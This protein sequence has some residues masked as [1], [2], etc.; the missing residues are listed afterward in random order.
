M[1]LN[2]AWPI[3][4]GKQFSFVR[5]P[6]GRS[7]IKNRNLPPNSSQHTSDRFHL[8]FSNLFIH[9]RTCIINISYRHNRGYLWFC[10]SVTAAAAVVLVWVAAVSAAKGQQLSSHC[11]W[12]ASWKWVVVVVDGT[13][14]RW[15][16]TSPCGYKPFLREGVGIWEENDGWEGTAVQSNVSMI[17]TKLG[18]EAGIG[19]GGG[20]C[21]IEESS[22]VSRGN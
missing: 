14:L 19:G 15:A 9:T 8:L 2:F 4:H 1:I 3:L 16:A 5:Y 12:V 7:A 20:C 22:G 18:V 17:R 13:S 10:V 11:L 6:E 21:C